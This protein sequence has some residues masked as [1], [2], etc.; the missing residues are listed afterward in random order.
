MNLSPESY[1][2]HPKR[3]SRDIHTIY[4][5]QFVILLNKRVEVPRLMLQAASV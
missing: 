5:H 4:T 3:S 1:L 2:D